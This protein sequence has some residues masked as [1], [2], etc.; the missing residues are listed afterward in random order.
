MDSRFAHR[1]RHWRRLAAELCKD[2]S[3]LLKEC[4]RLVERVK[5]LGKLR[6]QFAHGYVF[7]MS[8]EPR[9]HISEHGYTANRVRYFTELAKQNPNQR[10]L[11][12]ELH[13]EYTVKELANFVKMTRRI[14][15]DWLKVTN[16]IYPMPKL[17]RI[18][19]RKRLRK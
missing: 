12:S 17:A 4:D 6:S 2:K 10:I 18:P 7:Y 11:A 13:P 3:D 5:E 8:R 16:Q 14:D 19:R 1:L 9:I 15:K